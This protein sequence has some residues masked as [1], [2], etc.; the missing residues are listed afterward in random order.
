MMWHCEIGD[1]QFPYIEATSFQEG[2]LSLCPRHVVHEQSDQKAAAET[3]LTA[4][5]SL[6]KQEVVKSRV[7]ERKGDA[8]LQVQL[9]F[10]MAHPVSEAF[11]IR[12]RVTSHTSLP[13]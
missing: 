1:G 13:C 10:P 8:D 6:K 2:T 12:F 5:S 4:T 9:P 11:V 7:E 3:S